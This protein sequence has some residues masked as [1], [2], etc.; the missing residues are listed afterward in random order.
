MSDSVGK[1]SLDL[2][3]QSDLNGQIN[4]IAHKMGQEIQNAMK[5][6]SGSLDSEAFAKG[7]ASELE[8]VT[9]G[10]SRAIGEAFQKSTQTAKGSIDQIGQYLNVMIDRALARI[11]DVAKPFG[12]IGNTPAPSQ[13][14]GTAAQPRAPPGIKIKMPTLQVDFT[15]DMLQAQMEQIER[16]MQNIGKQVDIQEQKLADLKERYNNTFN[17]VRK[18]KLREQI[19]KTEGAILSLMGKMEDLGI[20][21]DAMDQKASDLKNK[22]A[23]G[24][25]DKQGGTGP[26]GASSGQQCGCCNGKAVQQVNRALSSITTT[27]NQIG[28]SLASAAASA[29][30]LSKA[31]SSAG[32]IPRSMKTGGTPVSG[33]TGTGTGKQKPMMSGLTSGVKT[34]TSKLGALFGL[35]GSGTARVAK[36][37]GMFGLFGR[38]LRQTGQQASSNQ[39]TM[40]RMLTTM[41][42]YQIIIPLVM[43]ALR[44]LAGS[45]MGSLKANQQ[46]SSSLKQIQSNLNVAFTPI[47]QAILPAIN[48]LMA[49]LARLSAYFAAFTSGIFG[50][51][52]ASSVAATK[53]LVKLKSATGAYGG[54][55]SKAAKSAKELQTSLMGI[56][57]VNRLNENQDSDAGGGGGGGGGPEI[58]EPPDMEGIDSAVMPWV[59]K[60]KNIMSRIFQPFREAWAA[61]GQNT[62]NAMRLALGN[63]WQ[64]VK[65]IGNSFLNV[66][67]NGTGTQVLSSILRIFQNIFG[68]IGNIA[69]RLDDAW[70][71]NGNGERII[72]GLFNLLQAVL[73][74]IGKI[75][76]ATSEWAATVNFGPLLKAVGD[77]IISLEP[78]IRAIGDIL[79]DIWE[80]VVLPFLSWLI[81]SAIPKVLEVLS[82]LFN[83]LG[84]HKGILEVLT[85]GVLG[86][87]AAFKTVGTIFGSIEG[88]IGIATALG[89]VFHTIAIG[90]GAVGSAIGALASPIG[91]VIAVIAALVAGGV[92]LYKNWDTIKAKASEV[93]NAVKAQLDGFGQFLNNVFA[94]DW[95]KAFGIFGDTLNAFLV[96][97]KGV[98]DGV[99]TIFEGIITFVTGVFS[100]NWKQAWDGVVQ[101][102]A[103]IMQG[104]AAVIKA[105]LNAVIGMVNGVIEGLNHLNIDIP[106][107][108]PGFGG[109]SFGVKIPKIQYLASGGVVSQPTLAMMGE[110]GKQEAVVPLDRNLGWRDAIVDKINEGLASEE[111]RGQG[112]TLDELMARLRVLIMEAVKLFAGL[113]PQAP[114]YNADTG[115]IIIPIYLEGS[116]LDEVII[117]AQQRKALRNGGK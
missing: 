90:A 20:Q 73:D 46:F 54:S 75:T 91:I 105:P 70:N 63:I 117:S 60:F 52:L 21:Y 11:T 116:M 35:I 77:V 108:V 99:K 39:G 31:L 27:V 43:S 68:I 61:E 78:V 101:I 81:E 95:S 36:T 40:H 114:Q 24:K 42:R 57:E 26:S 16:V 102:F 25:P 32:K 41:L 19:V 79:A 65:D 23:T 66:W 47:Y 51:S 98:L 80:T 86:F 94:A 100:G 93:W 33:G 29:A 110:Q 74:T 88:V 82:G 28:K 62:V 58:I 30:R 10:M 59:E 6:V 17:E 34:A 104:L 113:V 84:Q 5:G 71:A 9:Q 8:K 53:S 22:K 15:E 44:G 115:D 72:Q 7:L 111:N 50:K 12:D 83:F 92:L 106:D 69:Q 64:L 2:E 49:A 107:W 97:V 45:L 76:R 67:T 55:A 103:G 56:D 85:V 87:V 48:A 18:N 112:F 89:G 3:V 13:G 96:T 14:T 109:K 38:Q 37:A 1:V 4:E